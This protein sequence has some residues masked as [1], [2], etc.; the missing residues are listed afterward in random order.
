MMR[1]DGVPVV[2]SGLWTSKRRKSVSASKRSATIIFLAVWFL[3]NIHKGVISH[4]GTGSHRVGV[5]LNSS[6]AN[7]PSWDVAGSNPMS[8]TSPIF[9]VLTSD[10]RRHT[11]SPQSTERVIGRVSAW[12][13]ATLYLTSRLPQIWKNFTRKSVEGL[14]MSLFVCAFLGNL[15]YV[16]SIL[17]NPTLDEPIPIST[18]YISE[19]I[20]Y[21]LGSGGTLLFDVTIVAQSFI[22]GD[23]S[24]VHTR[25]NSSTSARKVLGH[26]VRSSG[27]VLEGAEF[28]PLLR[29]QDRGKTLTNRFGRTPARRYT[30]SGVRSGSMSI[31]PDVPTQDSAVENT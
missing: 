27:Y 9:S 31:S 12:V 19:S 15:F 21:L 2:E 3:F 11:W 24:P 16:A 6:F 20:P 25:L 17:T 7:D 26:R 28:E 1:N 22:Y 4:P 5:V 8:R 29:E 18:E 14:T 23:Q 10:D 30:H 13:C